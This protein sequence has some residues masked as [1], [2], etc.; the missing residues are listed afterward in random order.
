MNT[1]NT[2]LSEGSPENTI[3]SEMEVHNGS[4]QY[5]L[6]IV[7]RNNQTIVGT[8][9]QDTL[10]FQTSL[11]VI[12][13][14]L[15]DVVSLTENKLKLKNGS[16]LQGSMQQEV[17][18]VNTKYGLVEVPLA[19]ILSLEVK[20]DQTSIS[21]KYIAPQYS[22]KNLLVE[23]PAGVIINGEVLAEGTALPILS[24]DAEK[25]T[26]R[27]GSETVIMRRKD[28]IMKNF[29]LVMGGNN[30][31][32]VPS[33][34]K[35]N[36]AVADFVNKSGYTGV[37]AQ[38]I[39][40]GM[41]DMLTDA[42]V[43]SGMFV[44]LDRSMLRAVF[45]EQDLAVSGRTTQV[46]EDNAQDLVRAA[47]TGALSRAQVL[48]KGSITE[49]NPGV[50]AAGQTMSYRG[51][52][53]GSSKKRV[54]IAVIIYL[55]DTSTGQVLDSQRVE[56]NA[57]TGSSEFGVTWNRTSWGQSAF[58]QTPVGKA[59]QMAIDRAVERVSSRLIREPWHGRV[60]KVKKSGK[61]FI[62]TGSRAG[63]ALGMEYDVCTG[64][65]LIDPESGINLG[66]TLEPICRIKITRTQDNFAEC[67]V[68]NGYEP[69]LNDI[70][71]EVGETAISEYRRPGLK[72]LK[73]EE[74]SDTNTQ[75]TI[76]NLV[77]LK[78]QGKITKEEFNQRWNY[79][80]SGKG[81]LNDYK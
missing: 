22:T 10:S 76:Q 50:N 25:L 53:I 28:S 2:V 65:E 44:V 7:I 38:L 72:E 13:P 51:F 41:A 66:M 11:G 9:K 60:I 34:L 69:R 40:S 20:P 39:G 75:K 30:S 35:K 36:I 5:I 23:N 27:C 79:I 61:I 15:A 67:M 46:A 80:L 71:V 64:E 29:K 6:K 14:P 43:Q 70:V 48:I 18:G 33:V 57:E 26:I 32:R 45:A 56:G 74:E 3:P 73:R 77:K 31:R 78:K 21:Q 62:N 52:S 17:L 58:K 49:F 8:P 68:I 81:D 47:N 54:H 42:L 16:I 59:V 1:G 12:S 37:D 4:P 63:I 19:D 24:E 55:V